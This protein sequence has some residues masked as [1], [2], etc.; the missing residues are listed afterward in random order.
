M[1]GISLCVAAVLV[2]VAAQP[3]SPPPP[4]APAVTSQPKV[5]PSALPASDTRDARVT[6]PNSGGVKISM[7]GFSAAAP[8]APS[9]SQRADG[10]ITVP[11]N[12]LGPGEALWQRNDRIDSELKLARAEA[13]LAERVSTLPLSENAWG[14]GGIGSVWGSGGWGEWGG[15]GGGG[16][17]NVGVISAP[18]SWSTQ[19]WSSSSTCAVPRVGQVD[20]SS[21]GI[22]QRQ[23]SEAAR[24]KIAHIENARADAVIQFGRVA[25]G[26]AAPGGSTG[27]GGTGVPPVLSRKGRSDAGASTPAQSSSRPQSAPRKTGGRP[28][29]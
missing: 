9:T 7:P 16:W 8:A 4:A 14:W 2:S 3:S 25:A 19:S 18:R 17:G 22:A 26:A 15:W 10:L 27:P 5:A 12:T 23:F 11:D 6:L 20:R 29:K 1:I 28:R 13:F 21:V 24:P